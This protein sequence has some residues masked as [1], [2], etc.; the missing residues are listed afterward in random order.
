MLGEVTGE[1]SP[2]WTRSRTQ[3]VIGQVAGLGLLGFRGPS[4]LTLNN[5]K[6][7]RASVF[8]GPGNGLHFDLE[9][10]FPIFRKYLPGVPP[11]L[12]H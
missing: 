9:I 2:K 6:K 7:P 3:R 1:D 4:S 10:I 5:R 12:M 11:F 8:I